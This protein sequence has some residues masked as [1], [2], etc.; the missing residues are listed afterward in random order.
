MAPKIRRIYATLPNTTLKKLSR[1]G[2]LPLLSILSRELLYT[3]PLTYH[4]FVVVYI[5]WQF[6]NKRVN[7]PW[8]A[9]GASETFINTHATSGCLYRNFLNARPEKLCIPTTYFFSC[10]RGM[11]SSIKMI[12][13]ENNINILSRASS[14]W[15]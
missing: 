1:P 12:E 5:N 4:L 6:I 7:S 14:N 9:L 2:L 11:T 3:V 15:K 10:P 13:I 8:C